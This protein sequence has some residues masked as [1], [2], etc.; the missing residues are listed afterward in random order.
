MNLLGIE[1]G[2]T[3]L[4]LVTGTSEG[5]ILD[6]Q[7]ASVDRSLGGEGI[8]RWIGEWIGK[9]QGR[10]GWCAV[11]VGYGGP[12]DWRTGRV[13]CSHHVAGWDDFPLGDWLREQTGLPVAVDNDTNVA[14]YAEASCGAAAGA[15]PVFYTNSGSGVGGGC[16]VDGRIYHGATPGEAE[17]G[18][19]RLDRT[20]TI[21]ED[22][23]SGWALDRIVAEVARSTPG[24]VLAR[25]VRAET[26][27]PARALGPALAEGCPAAAR[28]IAEAGDSLAFALSHAVHLFH[29]EVIVLGG[30]VSLIGEP[31]R[32]AVAC[33]LPEYVMAA[34]QPGPEV[35][36]A[37]LGELAVP[38]GALL[39]AGEA[40]GVRQAK[41][42]PTAGR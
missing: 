17:L 34:F 21:V 37:G 19:L 16:V 10:F 31:W 36:L 5:K 27:A 26:G 22:R 42:S 25:E 24:S 7:Q 9:S 39:L 29:P 12:V 33:R 11:G 8:R 18:H 35:R 1:I 15:N 40:C 32:E 38:R 20:G 6:R 4:Q 23:C 14:A 41:E 30:G 28:V 2:G 3:K 13:H